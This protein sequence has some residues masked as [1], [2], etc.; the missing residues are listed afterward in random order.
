[1][2]RGGR[3]RCDVGKVQ[4]GRHPEHALHQILSNPVRSIRQSLPIGKD[5]QGRPLV[6]NKVYVASVPGDIALMAV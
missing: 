6:R 2:H 1:M 4:D 5:H 3:L